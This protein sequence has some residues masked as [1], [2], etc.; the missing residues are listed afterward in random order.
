GATVRRLLDVLMSAGRRSY[1]LGADDR[2]QR[3]DAVLREDLV[4][5]V[6]AI[7]RDGRRM[8]VDEPSERPGGW[9]R[10]SR[11]R[12]ACG[13]PSSEDAPTC[14]AAGRR[15]FWI[16]RSACAAPGSSPWRSC[17]DPVPW[18]WLCATAVS[19]TR[20]SHSPASLPLIS[21]RAAGPCG[22]S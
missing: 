9:A 1:L 18:P 8:P 19:T 21:P 11:R 6:A 12:V 10:G 14:A 15:A 13:S 3:R 22:P 2:P 20:R 5:R 16:W 7:I 17:Q 4:G